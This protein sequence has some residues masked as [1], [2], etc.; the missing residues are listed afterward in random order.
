M[1]AYPALFDTRQSGCEP[2]SQTYGPHA[3]A[4]VVE[5]TDAVTFTPKDADT[6]A[7][8][9]TWTAGQTY[10]IEVSAYQQAVNAWVHAS[11]GAPRQVCC[12]MCGS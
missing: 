11:G 12:L 2:P 6:R 9:A 1:A 7:L 3:A 10:D 8:A 5:P 4:G